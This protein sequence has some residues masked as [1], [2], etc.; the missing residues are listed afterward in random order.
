MVENMIILAEKMKFFQQNLVWILTGVSGIGKEKAWE[1]F[2]GVLKTF[3]EMN[4][5]N[6]NPHY[7]KS[8]S[9]NKSYVSA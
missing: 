6:S 2:C 7:P 1:A 3:S 8:V 4:S 9:K 5:F